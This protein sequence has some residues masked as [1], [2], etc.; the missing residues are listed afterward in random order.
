[1]HTPPPPRRR[2]H[3]SRPHEGAVM[4]VVLLILMVATASATLS[5]RTTQTELR[6]A[7]HERTAMQARYAAEGAAVTTLAFLQIRNDKSTLPALRAQFANIPAAQYEMAQFGEPVLTA[8][9]FNDFMRP[10][11]ALEMEEHTGDPALCPAPE[12]CTPPLTVG[13]GPGDGDGDGDGD[14]VGSV[15]SR[16]AYQPAS[17]YAVDVQDCIEIPATAVPGMPVGYEGPDMLACNVVARGRLEIPG[18]EAAGLPTRDW[19]VPGETYNQSRH[20]VLEAAR[21][22]VIIPAAD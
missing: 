9:T 21:A 15:G 20:T 3:H 4:M 2:R 6:A 7:G 14:A 10:T 8:E 19:N 1:M 11:M 13:T 18:V 12:G 17:D 5:V 22:T 16:Q